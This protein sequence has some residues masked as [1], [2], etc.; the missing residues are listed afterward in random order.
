MPEFVDSYF[1]PHGISA[2]PPP[3]SRWPN[4]RDHASALGVLALRPGI[5]GPIPRPVDPGPRAVFYHPFS[6]SLQRLRFICPPRVTGITKCDSEFGAG[7]VQLFNEVQCIG[8]FGSQYQL[9]ETKTGAQIM[10]IEVR[11]PR[12]PSGCVPEGV[13]PGPSGTGARCCR[14]SG[15]RGGGALG[16]VGARPLCRGQGCA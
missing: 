4:Q 14:C 2:P 10:L 8:D 16:P 5:A 6:P 7:Y 9:T 11:P 12:G 13:C 1:P 3:P 15:L